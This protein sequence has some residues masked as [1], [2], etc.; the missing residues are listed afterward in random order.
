MP[1]RYAPAVR[2]HRG[3]AIAIAV[4]IVAFGT[5]VGAVSIVLSWIGVTGYA[6]FKAFSGGTDAP[7][8]AGIIIGVVVLVTWLVAVLAVAIRLIG[9]GMEPPK[10][11][12]R[13]REAF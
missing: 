7:N 9:R 10:R 8:A 11:R 6:A 1:A 12:D 5:V 13:E 2:E 3:L 4:A